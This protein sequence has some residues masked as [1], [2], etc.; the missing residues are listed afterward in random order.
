MYFVYILTSLNEKNRSYVGLTQN[1]ARRVNEHNTKQFNYTKKFAP[2]K[3]CAYIAF[4]NK[5]LAKNFEKYLKSG[6]GFAFLKKR[7]FESFV[8]N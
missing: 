4:E 6:S 5:I 8:K 2:W 1:I 3:L 7:F